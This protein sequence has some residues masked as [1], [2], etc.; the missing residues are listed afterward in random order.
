ML[1]TLA[2]AAPGKAATYLCRPVVKASE[3]LQIKS[4]SHLLLSSLGSKIWF[5]AL[6]NPCFLAL[7]DLWLIALVDFRF[8]QP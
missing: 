2:S 5:L 3:V 7:A 1:R 6:A 4:L 8:F